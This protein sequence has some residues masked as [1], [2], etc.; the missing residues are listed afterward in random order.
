MQMHEAKEVVEA[1]S[2]SEADELLNAGWVLLAVV[3]GQR[4]VN[5]RD[6]IG[7]IYVLGKR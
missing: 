4:Y 2:V 5:G 1:Y 7:P 3:S 6:Q